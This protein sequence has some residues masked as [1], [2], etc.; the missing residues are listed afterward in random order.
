MRLTQSGAVSEARTRDVL[1]G[2][3]VLYQL[4]YYCMVLGQGSI[5]AS[6]PNLGGALTKL[7]NVNGGSGGGRTLS[8]LRAREV[9]YQQCF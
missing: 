2:R 5:P 3:Q 4:S 7:P 6:P 1:F 9:H 8:N